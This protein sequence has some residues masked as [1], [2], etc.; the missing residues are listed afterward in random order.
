MNAHIILYIFITKE[1]YIKKIGSKSSNHEV[2]AQSRY[3]F[4]HALGK[5]DSGSCN[6]HT[7]SLVSSERNR[8]NKF[9]FSSMSPL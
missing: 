7:P 2:D 3:I 9:S 4:S 1:M 5:S 6:K 8:E